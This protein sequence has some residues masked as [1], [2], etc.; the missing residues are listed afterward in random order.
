M[1]QFVLH[2]SNGEASFVNIM[3]DGCTDHDKKLAQVILLK[4]NIF[5]ANKTRKLEPWKG[6]GVWGVMEPH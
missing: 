3:L 6:A 1:E 2:T 4:K 5:N